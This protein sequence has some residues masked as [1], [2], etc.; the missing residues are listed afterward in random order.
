MLK[1]SDH[2]KTESSDSKVRLASRLFPKEI[3]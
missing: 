3:E 2:N 1:I